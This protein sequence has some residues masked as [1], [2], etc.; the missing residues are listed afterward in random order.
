[1]FQVGAARHHLEH[2]VV[3]DVV[4]AGDLQA[5]QLRAAL[6][7]H[8][9]PAV[10]EPLAA[11]HHHRLQGEAHIRGVLA[12]PVGQHPDGSVD[13]QQLPRQAHGAPQPRIPRQVVPPP[14]HACAAAQLI[15]GEV[16]EDLQEGVV[17]EEVDG[18]VVV[19]FRLAGARVGAG[20]RVDHG[21]GLGGGG[22]GGRG[23]GFMAVAGE[24][25]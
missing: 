2:G 12:Q 21:D 17:G 6:S 9:Q 18:G 16:G 15:G 13:V 20:C 19:A 23:V 4:T 11:V 7:H 3:G 10:R 8:V 5:A 14:T 1:M 24:G 22:G 25:G